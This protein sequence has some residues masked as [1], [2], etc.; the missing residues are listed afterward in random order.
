MEFFSTK[1][2]V[3][4]L[5]SSIRETC[6]DRIEPADIPFEFIRHRGDDSVIPVAVRGLDVSRKN[7][8][9]QWD[10]GGRTITFSSKLSTREG[11]DPDG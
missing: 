5:R 10:N 9:G 7:P 3:P 1:R 11:R 4:I 2:K 8:A 6:D